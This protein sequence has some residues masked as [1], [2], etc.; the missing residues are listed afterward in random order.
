[1][2]IWK[3]DLPFRLFQ[4][5]LISDWFLLI[6]DWF[7]L[8]EDS[9]VPFRMTYCCASE[10]NSKRKQYMYQSANN[11]VMHLIEYLYEC[12]KHYRKFSQALSDSD[13]YISIFKCEHCKI[14]YA[15]A[16][17]IANTSISCIYS[18]LSSSSNYCIIV[19]FAKYP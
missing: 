19:I 4:C 16:L 1:M 17:S 8:M 2:K 10:R 11:F 6:D 9:Y 3:A 7:L 18:Y 15:F 12:Q 13:K 14:K 5:L